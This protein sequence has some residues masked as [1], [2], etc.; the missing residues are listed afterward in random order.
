MKGSGT[1]PT[2]LAG[3]RKEEKLLHPGKYPHP[4]RKSA[5]TEKEL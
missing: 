1:V 2:L 5:G 4:A 3:I